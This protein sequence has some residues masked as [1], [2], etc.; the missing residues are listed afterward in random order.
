MLVDSV[1]I[2]PLHLLIVPLGAAGLALLFRRWPTFAGVVAL[3]ALSFTLFL[4]VILNT[5]SDSPVLTLSLQLDARTRLPLLT[6]TTMLALTLVF[7]LIRN[8]GEFFP[9]T[10]C[11]LAALIAAA[12][13]MFSRYVV[14][15]AV[16]QLAHVVAGMGILG[17]VPTR[18]VGITMIRY[19]LMVTL[20]G[21]LVVLGL[22]LVDEYRIS[23]ET[24]VSVQLIAA[25]LAVGFGTLIAAA[26]LYFWLPDVAYRAPVMGFVLIAAIL[27]TATTTFL[28]SV[29]ASF[30]WLTND[31]ELNALIALG[32]LATIVLGALLAYGTN[33]L[34]G[35]L[36][37]STVSASG[38]LVVGVA[39]RSALAVTGAL[40]Q[41]L[42]MTVA[43]FLLSVLVG[44]IEE[45]LGGVTFAQLA[46]LSARA[47]LLTLAFVVGGF[48]I[49]GVPGFASFPGRWLVFQAALQQGEWFLLILLAG[50]GLLMLAYAR[51]LRACL[52]PVQIPGRIRPFSRP[53]SIM[54]LALAVVCCGLGLYPSP[55]LSAILELVKDLGFVRVV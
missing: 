12:A 15:A 34:R 1:L 40:Y 16:L 7:H 17:R 21:A 20:G 19:A 3:S 8:Q 27:H 28:V 39:S 33:D 5:Q 54:A 50:S 9:A 11:V 53:G 2:T 31:P 36:G 32:G 52:R 26:P 24:E 55:I 46:G 35:L 51:A 30:P 23:P 29:L 43:L 44:V 18:Q 47:P 49:V 10:V 25:V 38:F 6:F 13:L 14:T 4:G 22:L 41:A 48:S 42:A 45:R 37:Y